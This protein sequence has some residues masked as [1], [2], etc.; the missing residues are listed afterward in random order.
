MREKLIIMR[1]KYKKIKKS[2]KSIEELVRVSFTCSFA[3]TKERNEANLT[4]DLTIQRLSN[5]DS[6]TR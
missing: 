6:M 5:A 3:L 1:Y 4:I 2:I